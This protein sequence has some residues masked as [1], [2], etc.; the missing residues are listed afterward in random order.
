MRVAD[1]AAV[2]W[3]AYDVDGEG[4]L[5]LND[6]KQALTKWGRAEA[7]GDDKVSVVMTNI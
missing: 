2:M 7:G 3:W 6:L 1:E 5:S 4:T